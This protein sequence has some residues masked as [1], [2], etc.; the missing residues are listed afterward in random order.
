MDVVC[1]AHRTVVTGRA[2]VRSVYGDLREPHLGLSAA[3]YTALVRRVDAVIHSAAVTDFNRT[4]GSLEATN[5]EGTKRILDFA[6]A[7][8]VPFYHLSTA[9]VHATVDGE[10]GR[11]AVGYAA[12]KRAGEDLVR[13]SG[14]P[15]V[16]FRPSVVVGDS[17][18]GEVRS[19]Q[20]LYRA[21]SAVLDGVAPLI[22][23]DRSWLLD[24][25]PVDVVADAV[26]TVVEQELTSGEFWITAGTRA[27]RL[28]HAVELCVGFGAEIGRV[29]DVPRFVAPEVFDRLIA[30]V[31]LD[32]LPVKTRTTVLR[33][34]DFFAAYLSVG[35]AFPSSL[36]DL[37]RMGGRAL[38]DPRA[39]LLSSLRY[40]ARATGR[41]AATSVGEVA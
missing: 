36:E 13:A 41:T 22:P 14:L 27:L 12:S 38:P 23:F 39:T 31:F 20:G 19:F 30:P 34:L 2:G 6:S 15:H 21:V 4:D 3:D 11:T 28:D 29:V 10:R 1:L 40:W 17:R 9:Y 18:T 8:G 7:A 5:V 32:A 33:L 35:T 24:F 25:V 26:A 37:V 16:I